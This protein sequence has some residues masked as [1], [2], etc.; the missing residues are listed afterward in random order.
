M[1]LRLRVRVGE[2]YNLVGAPVKLESDGLTCRPL[3]F[4]CGN[5]TRIDIYYNYSVKIDSSL[6]FVCSMRIS[7]WPWNVTSLELH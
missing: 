2:V 6:T 7:F 5:F 3:Y 1:L 4:T